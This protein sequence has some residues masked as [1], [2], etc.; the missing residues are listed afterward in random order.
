MTEKIKAIAIINI[1]GRPA[2]YLKEVMTK[3]V[4]HLKNE[5]GLVIKKERVEEPVLIKDKIGEIKKTTGEK[6]VFG[7]FCE[8]EIEFKDFSKLLGFMIDYMPTSV[9]IIEP[10]EIKINLHDVNAFISDFMAKLHTY[11]EVTKK[12]KLERDVL[13]NQVKS[14][15][16]SRVRVEEVKK[17]E[18]KK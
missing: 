11:D 17:E 1:V 3:V 12:L 9:E 8:V 18:D 5:K 4:E 14:M 7:T 10:P 13:I 2:D 6:D 16:K 15:M